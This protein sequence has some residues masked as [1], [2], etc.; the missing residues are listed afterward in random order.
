[1]LRDKRSTTVSAVVV[2]AVAIAGCGGSG[3]Q[4]ATNAVKKAK[5]EYKKAQAATETAKF[6]VNAI[7]SAHLHEDCATLLKAEKTVSLS[8]SEAKKE[9]ASVLAKDGVR[10]AQAHIQLLGP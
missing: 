2:L 8:S 3:Q 9:I 7:T 10:C 5:T 1:M 4:Q 6:K